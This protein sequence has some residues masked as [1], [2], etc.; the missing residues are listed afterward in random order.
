MPQYSVPGSTVIHDFQGSRLI[1]IA[2]KGGH[3]GLERVD[4]GQWPRSYR[5]VLQHSP[6]QLYLVIPPFKN[7]KRID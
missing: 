6:Y 5:H 7:A 3:K 2:R 1:S 4:A